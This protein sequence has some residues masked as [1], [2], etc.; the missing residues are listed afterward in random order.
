MKYFRTLIKCKLHL[1]ADAF[2]KCFCRSVCLSVCLSV[3]SSQCQWVSRW[4]RP[5]RP[6]GRVEV[7]LYCFLNL[8]TRW[9]W[10]VNATPQPLYPRERD[11]VPIV[12]EGGWAPEP[13]GWVRKISS[14][15][16]FDQRTVQ[17]VR[18]RCTDRALP[19]HLLPIALVTQMLQCPLGARG[20]GWGGGR[21]APPYVWLILHIGIHFFPR[22]W[23]G[24][25]FPAPT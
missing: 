7:Y 8:G 1:A 25:A 5:W 21:K 17:P 13:C 24:H 15:P 22:E 14:L 20:V 11:P 2:V 10:V 18:T 9:G 6:R 23:G 12:Q 4:N 3:L 16:G 19:A